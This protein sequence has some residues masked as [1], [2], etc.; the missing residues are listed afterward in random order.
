MPG[1]VGNRECGR[2]HRA[3]GVDGPAEVRRA[4]VVSPKESAL[5]A[6]D[7]VVDPGY[8]F[9]KAVDLVVSR[10]QA[11]RH[12]RHDCRA[13]LSDDSRP[14]VQRYRPRSAT[15]ANAHRRDGADLEV[16]QGKLHG[17][18]DGGFVREPDR[19]GPREGECA[20]QLRHQSANEDGEHRDMISTPL[21]TLPRWPRLR[22]ATRART[23]VKVQA[24]SPLA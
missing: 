8:G 4:E 22:S 17:G 2:R 18:V 6:D 20:R 23:P 19:R 5:I 9:V 10:A 21:N 12:I 24:T 13:S 16:M 3:A 14:A 7:V 15:V 11:R 1:A